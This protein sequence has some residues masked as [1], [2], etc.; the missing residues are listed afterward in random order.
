MLFSF[1]LIILQGF[2]KF[3]MSL[4]KPF[5]GLLDSIDASTANVTLTFRECIEDLCNSFFRRYMI[6]A[7]HEY[8]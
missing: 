2:I 6:V 7:N 3:Y 4:G 1:F 5:S 8:L